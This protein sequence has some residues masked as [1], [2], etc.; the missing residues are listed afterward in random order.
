MLKK[1][2]YFIWFFLFLMLD[3]LVFMYMM[4][5]IFNK[6]M[7]IIEFSL[8]DYNSLSFSYLVLIDWICLSFFFVV[9]FISS[10]VLIYSYQYMGEESYSYNRFL[11]LVILFVMS[12]MLMIMSPNLISILVGWDGL[13]LTS[14]CLVIYYS[15]VKSYLSGLITCLTNRLGD[16]GLLISVCWMFSYGSWHF[17]FYNIFYDN[18]IFFLVIISCFTKSAQIPFSSWLPAAMA[19]PTPVSALVHSSTLVTAGVYLLIRFYKL[20][21]F[22]FFFLLITMLTMIMSSFCALFEFDLKKIIAF[23]T[24]SQLGLMMSSLLMNMINHSYIHLLTHAMFKSLIFLCAGIFIYYMNNNQDIRFMGSICMSMPLTSSCFNISSISLCGIPFMSGFY[25]KDLII[26]SSVF[27]SMNII[28]FMMF[29][30]SLGL[31]VGYSLR[32]FY[33]T[34]MYNNY[35]SM[36]NFYD[37]FDFMK[38][39]IFSL[40]FFSLFFGSFLMWITQLDMFFYSLPFL[41]KIMSMLSIIMGLWLFFESMFFKNFNMNYS[42]YNGNM[43]FMISWLIYMNNYMFNLSISLNETLL[44]WGEYYGPMG[45]SFLLKYLS[46]MMQMYFFN[47]M[48]IFMLSFLLWLLFLL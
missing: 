20:F 42:Y 16:I 46:N 3:I 15:S 33:Y 37:K 22:S 32:L 4:I 29:Y 31:T 35:N 43:W 2:L 40:T 41:L 14:Y 38:L 39:S 17:M 13:G 5:F 18:Y 47:S 48:K 45:L 34:M 21:D 44:S 6:N 30:F 36:F 27:F 9:L 8:I 1:K 26:E 10:M 28:L 24:L 19:A 11:F 7:F 25:S 23:S 12:M